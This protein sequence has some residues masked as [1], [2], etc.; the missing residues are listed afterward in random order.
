M[1]LELTLLLLIEYDQWYG[2]LRE[3]FI[4]ITLEHV[5]VFVHFKISV[6]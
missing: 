3:V 6:K 5:V 2:F 4:Q 1:F